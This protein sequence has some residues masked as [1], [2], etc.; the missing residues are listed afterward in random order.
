MTKKIKKA[1]IDLT[2]DGSFLPL[3][4]Q[5]E[6]ELFPLGKESII[7]VLIKEAVS[8]GVE[9]IIFLSPK[10]NP[11]LVNLFT[12]LDKKVGELKRRGDPQAKQMKL[13]Q[14]ELGEL[15]FSFQINLEEAVLGGQD[16][17]Y[18]LAG[19]LIHNEK[20]ALLQLMNVFKTSERPV[21]GLMEAEMGEVKTEKIARGLFKF[22]GFTDQS[23]FSMIGRSVFTSESAKFFK[24]AKT[25]KEAVKNMINRGHTTYGTKI[26][27]QLFKVSGKEDYQK[28]N[29]YYSLKNNKELQEFIKEKGLL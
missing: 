21:I 14:E 17:V 5:V 9:E 4:E 16:F 15:S 7:E 18:I 24:G 13:L 11:R 8:V 12:G 29:I 19:E 10:K 27:G 2:E 6:K 20:N 28:A 25:I 26:N 23:Q 1:I 3:S 22:K